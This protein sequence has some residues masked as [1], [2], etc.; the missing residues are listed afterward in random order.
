MNGWIRIHRQLQENKMWGDRPF[1]KG[2]AW[3]DLLILASWKDNKFFKRG[4]EIDQKEGT[5]A[6]SMKGLSARWG[7]S[8]GK[9]K[10]FLL[11][12]ENENQ[13][14][15][16]INNVTTLIYIINWKEY[17][18][19]ETK[20][21][22]RRKPDG[23]QT[24]TIEEV[25]EVNKEPKP[26]TENKFSDKDMELTSWIWGLI[27]QLDPSRKKPNFK[28]WANSIR[29]MRDR[30]NLTHREI[31]EV[32]KWANNDPFWKSNIL[33]VSKLREKYS[34]LKIKMQNTGKTEEKSNTQKKLD[35]LGGNDVAT[36][37]DQEEFETIDITPARLCPQS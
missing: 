10:R 30:D 26:K 25:K 11:Y 3:I 36:G 18:E 32:F 37:T 5:V 9:V 20:M 8:I 1:A 19:M 23:N 13:I 21:E 15:H 34:D 4:L 12:L 17:Q 31:A 16:Q 14:E 27:L 29:L 33:S 7:W 24:E 35:A 22:T 28:K 6:T 2:Q